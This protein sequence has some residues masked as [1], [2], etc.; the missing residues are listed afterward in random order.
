MAFGLISRASDFLALNYLI[1]QVEH[2][3][4]PVKVTFVQ[5]FHLS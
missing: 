5:L 1:A 3:E 2:P 4:D